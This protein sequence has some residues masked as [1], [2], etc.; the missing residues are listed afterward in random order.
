MWWHIGR[1]QI[2][3]QKFAL[4]RV[5]PDPTESQSYCGG[6]NHKQLIEKDWKV[7]NLQANAIPN[8]ALLVIEININTVA[9]DDPQILRKVS[10]KGR[11]HDYF[12]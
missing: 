2:A 8:S 10:P 4:A 12:R 6:F 1:T 9:H 3:R 7:A 5:A 11:F